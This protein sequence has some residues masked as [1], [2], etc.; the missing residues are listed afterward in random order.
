MARASN[1][2][3]NERLMRKRLAARLRQRR[4][5]ER[6]RQAANDSLRKAAA[7]G[8]N[9]G[10]VVA[11][12][13]KQANKNKKLRASALAEDNKSITSAPVAAPPMGMTSVHM[14]ALSPQRPI[15][16]P[17]RMSPYRHMYPASHMPMAMPMHHMSNPHMGPNHVAH[18]CRAGA[19]RFAAPMGM[20][21]H[22]APHVQLPVSF[23]GP[24]RL[25]AM[26]SM[27]AG[28]PR[29]V[30]R[31][32]SDESNEKHAER[33]VAQVLREQNKTA[34][35]VYEHATVSSKV[36]QTSNSDKGSLDKK[37][38]KKRKKSLLSEEKTAVAAILSLKTSSEEESCDDAS[39][40]SASTLTAAATSSNHHSAQVI[41]GVVPV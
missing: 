5:R 30:S 32:N 34:P 24:A 17:P 14:S 8:K 29:T 11:A 28:M 33:K 41:M 7:E 6:K 4:C 22:Q 10:S 19:P 1:Y 15:F 40:T 31:S 27:P 39:T 25:Y 37:T 3:P 12:R 36:V 21:T 23:T 13:L 9:L 26:P 18:M 2:T 16:H 20:M 38:K 35:S